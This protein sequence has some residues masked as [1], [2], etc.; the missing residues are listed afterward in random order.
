M[1]YD[2]DVEWVWG[3]NQR[4]FVSLNTFVYNNN[5]QVR[6]DIIFYGAAKL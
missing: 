6:F 4:Q 5:S 2:K 1:N 3:N